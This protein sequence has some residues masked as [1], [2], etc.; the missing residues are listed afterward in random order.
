MFFSCYLFDV[1]THLLIYILYMF[2]LMLVVVLW[3]FECQSTDVRV[4]FSLRCGGRSK[5]KQYREYHVMVCIEI[6]W[7]M[8][9]NAPNLFLL[10]LP[11]FCQHRVFQCHY[12]A[13][14][15]CS[16]FQVA[17]TDLCH[18]Q[19]CR[20]KRRFTFYFVI[21]FSCLLWR[22]QLIL[23]CGRRRRACFRH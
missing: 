18:Y 3:F 11:F 21:V 10:M 15:C 7:I 16:S 14:E 23:H 2:C 5:Q 17:N 1:T 4:L 9:M 22:P 12:L 19:Q 8:G 20:K 13:S 6:N